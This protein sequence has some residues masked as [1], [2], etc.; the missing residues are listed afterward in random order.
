MTMVHLTSANVQMAGL[1]FLVMVGKGQ[2]L[3]E[4]STSVV[5]GWSG[6]SC[7]CK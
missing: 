5:P 1:C 7:K 4:C 2:P 3:H 6:L